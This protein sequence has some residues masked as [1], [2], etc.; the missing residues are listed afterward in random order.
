MT[1]RD[2]NRYHYSDRDYQKTDAV[3]RNPANGIA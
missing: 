3:R 1:V 2:G